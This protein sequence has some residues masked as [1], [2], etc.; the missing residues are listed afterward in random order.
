MKSKLQGTHTISCKIFLWDYTTKIV[1]SDIDGTIT[2]S[3]VL[4]HVLPKFGND[5]SHDHVCEL[6][7]KI[8]GNGYKMLYLTARAIGQ[9][10]TTQKYIKNLKQENLKLP[11]GAIIMSPDR[12]LRSFSREIILKK[13]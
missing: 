13:P 7:N 5:W 3:D 9:A 10:E 8:S 6:M 2:K 12:L 11:P 4:G 1:I